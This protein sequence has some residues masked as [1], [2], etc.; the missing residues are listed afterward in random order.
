MKVIDLLN[1]IANGEELPY[2]IIY[3][4]EIYEYVEE[5]KWYLRDDMKCELNNSKKCLNDEVE[6]IEENKNIILDKLNWDKND[7]TYITGE[8]DNE[9]VIDIILDMQS[10]INEIIDYLKEKKNEKK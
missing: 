6:V 4:G 10:T 9:S 1:K 2:R 8:I 5:M 7:M 3:N